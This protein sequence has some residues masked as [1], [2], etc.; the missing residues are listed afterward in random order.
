MSASYRLQLHDCHDPAKTV[1]HVER[2]RGERFDTPVINRVAIEGPL[3][4]YWPGRLP[5][6]KVTVIEGA[7][8]SGKTRL[9][10]DLAAR[11]GTSAPL[12][13]GAPNPWPAEDVLVISRH[14][15]EPRSIASHFA[16]SGDDSR[17]L[18]QFS[19]FLTEAP[20]SDQYGSRPI[21]FPFDMEALDFTLE[22]HGSIGMV[23]ID[24]LSDFCRTPQD[25][26]ET[27][28]QLNDLAARRRIV[29]VVTVPANCRTDCEGRLK[30]TSRWATD[31]GRWV[32]S[33]VTD[34]DDPSRRLLASRR[35]NFCREP[36]GLAFRI[37]DDGVAWE[38]DTKVSPIDPLGQLTACDRSLQELLRVE[39]LPATTVY[40]L[41]AELGYRPDDLRA[42]AKRIG[43]KSAR[44]GFGGAGRWVWAL[45]ELPGADP[46]TLSRELLAQSLPSA[47]EPPSQT[48]VVETEHGCAFVKPDGRIEFLPLLPAVEPVPAVEPDP[49]AESGPNM[50]GSPACR[51]AGVENPATELC[52]S[53]ALEPTFDPS[54]VE[55]RSSVESVIAL[56]Q[57]TGDAAAV[58]APEPRQIRPLSKRKAK[59]ERQRLARMRAA[60]FQKAG[61][62]LTVA[63]GE[64][65]GRKSY[66]PST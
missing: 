8:G 6:G 25:F 66:A 29:F 36:D 42:A 10:F 55:Q 33:I 35:A 58:H 2:P 38:A 43:A 12:P 28:H 37:T 50:P 52:E 23:I 21:A 3:E 20:S 65:A 46:V 30:V 47:A 11:V 61:P 15:D 49:A 56:P 26:E 62:G 34:P 4:W 54:A 51:M 27:L 32:W 45:T 53:V 57:A 1:Y 39:A 40:W 64:P 24:P 31:A 17:K 60:G 13:D 19:E 14:A 9:A 44:I 7:S 18:L 48:R 16:A 5:L 59:K 63:A 41:G 22:Q